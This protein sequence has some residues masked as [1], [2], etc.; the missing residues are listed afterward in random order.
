M[1]ALADKLTGAASRAGA[2]VAGPVLGKEL[3]VT[4]RRAR[5]YLLR[6]LYLT[7]LTFFV[8]T[9]SGWIERVGAGGW[10]YSADI[11]QNITQ[12]VLQFQAVVA[13]VLAAVLLSGAICGEYTSGTIWSLLATPLDVR[14]LVVGK[15]LSGLWQ[16]VVLLAM[17]LPL[18]AVVR[19]FGGVTWDGLLAGLLVVLSGALFAGSLALRL[20]ANARSGWSALFRTL[21]WYL[22]LNGGVGVFLSATTPASM[23]LALLPV[24][25][26]GFGLLEIA[27]DSRL[28]GQAVPYMLG[29]CAVSLGVSLLLLLSAGRKMR[30]HLPA[31]LQDSP[32]G[33]A[34]RR[35]KRQHQREQRPGVGSRAVL[36]KDLR[37]FLPADRRKIILPA[38]GAVV[39]GGMV[40]M[41]PSSHDSAG[42]HVGMV[43]LLVCSVWVLVAC[44]GATSLTSEKQTRALPILLT[45]PLDDWQIVGHKAM[46]A[47]G[48]TAVLWA[49]AVGHVLVYTILG[50]MRI[51]PVLRFL[52]LL[53]TV[54]VFVYALGTYVSA[55]SRT[56]SGA[57]VAILVTCIVLWVVL[58]LDLNPYHHVG[59]VIHW[60]VKDRLDSRQAGP[61]AGEAMFSAANLLLGGLLLWRGKVQMRRRVFE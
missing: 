20:S 50:Y 14:Q 49:W 31:L 22:V 39:S 34:L 3:R 13:Q 35:R 7:A 46:A 30:E 58:P 23:G 17:S 56:N 21:V 27:F 38:I 61:W 36:W 26:V 53:V 4:S 33:G 45:A 41:V 32:G 51:L 9:S 29:H 8:W 1:G 12:A 5:H 19:A 44:L 24:P 15:L 47:A 40:Y 59:N 52:L 2:W 42:F 60:A 57:I 18:L 28:G 16:V 10:A 37:D 43:G 48:R 55:R 6:F 25:V 11:G 54:T